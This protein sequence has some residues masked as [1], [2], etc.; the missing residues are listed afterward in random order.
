MILPSGQGQKIPPNTAR[1]R[2]VARDP[3]VLLLAGVVVVGL[4]LRVGLAATDD[5]IYWPDEIYQSLEPAHKITFGYGLLPWEF[6][7]GA[8]SWTFPGLLA[9]VLRLSTLLGLTPPRGYLDLVRAI[10]CVLGAATALGCYALARA[11]RAERLPAAASAAL[12][13]LAA[14]AIYFA[15]RALTESATTLPV[16]LGLAMSLRPNVGPRALGVGASLLGIA[17]LLR[18]QNGIFC[19]GLVAMLTCRGRA[20]PLAFAALVLAAWALAYGLV[21]RLTWGAFYQSAIAYLHIHTETN[22]VVIARRATQFRVEPAAYYLRTLWLAWG[23]AALLTGALALSALRR[24]PALLLL[25][26]GFVLVHSLIPHKELRFI[27]P[28]LPV[29]CALAG[30]GLQAW[31][32]RAPAVPAGALAA[33]V[34]AAALWSGLRFHRLTEADVGHSGAGSQRSAYDDSGGVNRLLEAAGTR[35]DLC[36]LKVEGLGLV[37][38]GGQ[39]YLHRSVPLY[40]D[41]G[42]PRERGFFNYVITQRSPKSGERDVATDS[43]YALRKLA[44]VGC[45]PDARY[46]WRVN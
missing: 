31:I 24:A 14:P 18:L 46:P 3:A 41:P 19:V 33:P 23:P 13:A 4:A 6:V 8:R 35:A 11:F 12:F 26:V 36:G 32:D 25:A 1:S 7:A 29:W 9:G 34:L 38:T 39:T 43:G 45:E 42:P 2:S 10:L 15:P 17:T 27:L 30:V 21:D 28:I 5:G 22:P 20:R 40:G 37:L 16:V 44:R